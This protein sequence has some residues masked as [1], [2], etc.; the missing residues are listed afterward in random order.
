MRAF[1]SAHRVDLRSAYTRDTAPDIPI[2]DL[3]LDETEKIFG[4]DGMT[5]YKAARD[6]SEGTDEAFARS[7]FAIYRRLRVATAEMRKRV[8]TPGLPDVDLPVYLMVLVH[9]LLSNQLPPRNKTKPTLLALDAW[10]MGMLLF[11]APVYRYFGVHPIYMDRI[12]RKVYRLRMLWSMWNQWDPKS[13]TLLTWTL[14][15]V[16]LEGEKSGQRAVRKWCVRVFADIAKEFV[17]PS[18]G[19]GLLMT[20]RGVLWIPELLDDRAEEFVK[21]IDGVIACVGDEE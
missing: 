8:E 16:A 10:R 19:T 13:R 2:P 11:L 12:V 6:I 7:I 4:R 9:E 21:E 18:D 15:M 14:F 1:L 20:A 17:G 5:A 3:W